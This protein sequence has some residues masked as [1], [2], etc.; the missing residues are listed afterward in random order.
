MKAIFGGPNDCFRYLLECELGLGAGVL[1][2]IMVNPSKA[3]SKDAS[4][5]TK[6]DHTATKVMRFAERGGYAKVLLGNLFAAVATDISELPGFA[7]PIGPENDYY[8]DQICR[9][10]NRIMV[11]WGT[12]LKLPPQPL[13]RNRYLAAIEAARKY[14]K[15]L[16]C[17]GINSD[18]HPKHPLML[19]YDIHPEVWSPP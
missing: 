6:S 1:G 12:L 3:G 19:S 15:P 4:G 11:A 16:Y 18:G 13:F 14:H 7:D 5:K 9:R 17:W 2:V 10:S 8:L